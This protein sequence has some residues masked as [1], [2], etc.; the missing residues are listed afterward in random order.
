M[1]KVPGGVTGEEVPD[2]PAELMGAR[3]DGDPSELR[4]L[5]VAVTRARQSL[6]LSHCP[7]LVSALGLDKEGEA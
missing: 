6:D 4:L 3:R 2:T 5:Y 1:P 7:L